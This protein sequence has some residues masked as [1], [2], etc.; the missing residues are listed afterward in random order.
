MKKYIGCIDRYSRKGL[1]NTDSIGSILKAFNED[2][3][4]DNVY[5]FKLLRFQKTTRD[6][7]KITFNKTFEFSL[8][9]HTLKNATEDN[10]IDSIFNI[11]I[12]VYEEIGG[13]KEL[14]NVI[15]HNRILTE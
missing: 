7:L 15:L 5:N 14:Q 11:L 10:N 3:Q 12:P 6:S 13:Y 8:Y 9:S 2:M 1:H 4:V